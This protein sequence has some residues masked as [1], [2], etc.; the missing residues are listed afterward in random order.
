MAIALFRFWLFVVVVT[1]LLLLDSHPSLR[2]QVLSGITGTITDTP[3]NAIFSANVTAT[4]TA[5]GVVSHTITTSA[6]TY[7]I[8]DLIPTVY[9]VRIEMPGFKTEIVT[10]VIV[11]L[12]PFVWRFGL[13]RSQKSASAGIHSAVDAEPCPVQSALFSVRT[14]QTISA[15]EMPGVVTACSRRAR[16]AAA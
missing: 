9:S 8:T 2:A 14:P 1:C 3:G 15:S 6:G 5:T 16:S 7:V 12:R 11:E 10:G 13:N 4:N